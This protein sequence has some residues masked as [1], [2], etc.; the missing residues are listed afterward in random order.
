MSF[1]WNLTFTLALMAAPAVAGW[2]L[3]GDVMGGFA[4]HAIGIL[5]GSAVGLLISRLID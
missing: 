5:A 4:G 3:I 1:R 2:F